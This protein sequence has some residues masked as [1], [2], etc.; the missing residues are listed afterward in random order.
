MSTIKTYTD[1]E[2]AEYWRN[3]ALKQQNNAYNNVHKPYKGKYKKRQYKSRQPGY[4]TKKVVKSSNSA[5]GAGAEALGSAAGMAV[6]GPP[7]AILGGI[8]GRGAHAMFK[9]VTGFGDYQIQRN[10]LMMGGMSPPMIVNSINR[11]SVIVRHRE[12]LGDINATTAFTLHSY[13]LNPG[14]VLT[15]PWLSQ[16][17]GSYEEYRF[18]GMIF[19]F[20]SLSSDAVLSTATSSALGAV[21]M[22]TQYDVLDSPFANKMEM[23]NYEFAN[24]SKPSCSFYHPIEC[25][26]SQTPGGGELYVR[27]GAVPSNADSRL[28]DLGNFNIATVGMQA[29]SGV[30]GEL[31]CT[32]EIEFFK[33][34]F[35]PAEGGLLDHF[36]L[37]GTIAAATP[38]GT[39]AAIRTTGSTLGGTIDYSGNKYI[40]PSSIPAGSKFLIQVLYDG[41]V[42][43]VIVDPTYT[44]TN[45]TL[46]N[47]W[48]AGTYSIMEAPAAGTSGHS[49]TRTFV[50][51]VDSDTSVDDTYIYFGTTGTF[52]NGLYL[53]DIMVTQISSTNN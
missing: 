37:Q 34:K 29:D 15:F 45:L 10:T 7:G 30:A 1:A 2:K 52:S 42:S 35:N 20:K 8:L 38:L 51:Q 53:K 43:V 40:F 5:W 11:G 22:A 27:T 39:L 36:N 21:I 14:Q 31:W 3:K 9:A 23:E 48:G 16:M 28:Y 19:E 32:Y 6:G 12:Y 25:K 13:P 17:A 44:Y 4:A 18:R 47:F 33:P 46:L 49:F 41:S 24:S 26:R 50:L